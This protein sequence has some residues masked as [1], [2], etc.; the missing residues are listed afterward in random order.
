MP[1]CSKETW[2][3]VHGGRWVCDAKQCTHY[4]KGG[5]CKLGKISLTCDN[6]DCRWNKQL[7][8]GIYGCI[9]MDVHLN[10]DGKCLGFEKK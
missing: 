7:A 9:S 2:I 10:A 8:P 4:L 5:G 6:N 1:A 3:K